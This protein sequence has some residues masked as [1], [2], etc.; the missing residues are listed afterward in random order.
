MAYNQ[1]G[2]GLIEVWCGKAK[3]LLPII[4]T[5]AL[6]GLLYHRLDF[7]RIA[8]L[9]QVA[10]WSV[11]L[12]A[13]FLTLP[14]V[15]LKTLKWHYLLKTNQPQ[16]AYTLALRSFLI[17]MGVSLFTPA[18]V[19]E[20]ARTACFPKRRLEVFTLVLIDKFIDMSALLGGMFT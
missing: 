10:D 6:V 14:F 11:L 9:R 8:N 17:G 20:L 13:A 15:L 18:R 12:I 5:A 16:T 7:H 4:G 2:N 3:W 19:G 1:N